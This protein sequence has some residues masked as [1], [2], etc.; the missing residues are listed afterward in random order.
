MKRPGRLVAAV[1]LAIGILAVGWAPA[2]A[3][4]WD[5]APG[6][7]W[8]IQLNEA[9]DTR[10]DVQVYDVDLWDTPTA[11]IAALR[12]EGRRVICYFSA[13]SRENWRPDANRFPAAA[14]GKP[15]DGWAGE[16]WLDIRSAAVREIMRDRL[17]LARTKGCDAVDPDNVDGYTQRSGFPLTARHQ[18]TYNRF[19]A[20]EAHARGLA[21]GLKNDVEQ[22][23]SLVAHFD[24]AVNEECFKYDECETLLP[25]I[26]AGKPVFH[27][28]YGPPGLAR[29]I[30]PRAND[31]NFDTLI[32]KLNLDEQR[33]PCR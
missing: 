4:W 32:K 23:P 19:L 3:A 8:Q 11:T 22:I 16:R 2:R 17:D 15:L 1:V 24:F 27:I 9:P 6:T 33:T 20:A 21:V 25:F 26:E 12:A 10:F 5:P 14:V 7:T 30:C 31:L 28:E 13:G 18:L 29:R